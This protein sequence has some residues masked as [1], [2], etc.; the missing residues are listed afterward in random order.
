M[1]AGDPYTSEHLFYSRWQAQRIPTMIASALGTARIL[2]AAEAADEGLAQLTNIGPF[3]LRRLQSV[4]VRS[5]E[6][7]RR[8]GAVATWRRL[9]A[10]W[11]EDTNVTTLYALYGA[12]IGVR[13]ENLP[14]EVQRE[15]A[16]EAA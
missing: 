10:A 4:G 15:L 13:W 8:L 11:P 16:A 2:S 14:P 7:L 5:P 6:V 12:L 3:T 1:A 9:K